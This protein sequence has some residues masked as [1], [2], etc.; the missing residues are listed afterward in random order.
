M[1]MKLRLKNAELAVFPTAATWPF[2]EDPHLYYPVLKSFLE[3][4]RVSG[5]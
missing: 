4:N 5:R 2:Y 3:R 1:E